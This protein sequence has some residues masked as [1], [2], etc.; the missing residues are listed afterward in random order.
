MYKLVIAMLHALM[1]LCECFQIKCS[2]ASDV[3]TSLAPLLSVHVSAVMSHMTLLCPTMFSS[4]PWMF[5]KR[6]NI[7]GVMFICDKALSSKYVYSLED[8]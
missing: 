4:P 1:Y 5:L 7:Q 6:T 3:L 2:I 8:Y